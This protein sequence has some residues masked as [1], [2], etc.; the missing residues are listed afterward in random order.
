MLPLRAGGYTVGALVQTNFGRPE[1]LTVCGVPVGK[2]LRPPEEEPGSGA[3][4]VASAPVM[5]SGSAFDLGGSIMMIL[6]TDAPL[7]ARGLGRLCR[8]AAFGL[9]RTGSTCHGGS[10]DFVIAFSTAHR[11]PDRPVSS[12]AA[13]PVI[14]EQPIMGHFSAATDK[15]R[16]AV[17]ADRIAAPFL[18][19]GRSAR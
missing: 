12:L 5:L 14:D 6:A 19:L 16:L 18:V 7:E 11:I 4:A 1:E 10:G 8:R 13:R 3:A 15:P 9:A 17:L 2:Y